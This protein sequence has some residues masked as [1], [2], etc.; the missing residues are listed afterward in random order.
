MGLLSF[1]KHFSHKSSSDDFSFSKSSI[2][3]PNSKYLSDPMR[4]SDNPD[5][6]GGFYDPI[7]ISRHYL[8]SIDCTNTGA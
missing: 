8:Q 3:S 6:V 7:S 4:T 2:P 5:Y 1:T